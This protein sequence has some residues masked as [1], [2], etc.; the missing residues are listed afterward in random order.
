MPPRGRCVSVTVTRFGVAVRH[1]L[2]GDLGRQ[3]LGEDRP[4]AEPP[5]VELEALGFDAPLVGLVLDHDA[6]TG[7]AARSPGTPS[8]LVGGERTLG[9]VG[10]AG[11]T[12][13]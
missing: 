11:N 7:R 6:S 4:I 10:G 13:T 1:D 9:D 5:Q 2:A 3:R 12:S 8:Q